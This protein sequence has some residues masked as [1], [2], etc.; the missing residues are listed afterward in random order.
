MIRRPIVHGKNDAG[1]EVDGTVSI[2]FWLSFTKVILA[3]AKRK[4]LIGGDVCLGAYRGP[5]QTFPLLAR[6][7]FATPQKKTQSESAAL[8]PTW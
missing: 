7:G 3:S 1:L 4:Y 8:W 5:A 2:F 6:G